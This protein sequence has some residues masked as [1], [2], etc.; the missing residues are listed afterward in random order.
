MLQAQLNVGQRRLVLAHAQAH[1]TRGKAELR[2][3]CRFHAKRLLR[4]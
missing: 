1:S 4:L 2:R 3:R